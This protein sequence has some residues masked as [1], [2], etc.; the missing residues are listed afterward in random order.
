MKKNNNQDLSLQLK[1]QKKIYFNIDNG[2]KNIITNQ[3]DYNKNIIIKEKKTFG[4]KKK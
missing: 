4:R 2:M 3:K 1:N